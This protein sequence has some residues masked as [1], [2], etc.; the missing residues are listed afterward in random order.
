MHSQ[1]TNPEIIKQ[2]TELVAKQ[3]GSS[4]I[5]LNDTGWDSRVYSVDDGRFFFK[6]PRSEKIQGRYAQEIAALELA[7]HI[8]GVTVPDVRWYDP[9]NR[10]FGYQGVPGTLLDN[11][12]SSLSTHQKTQ[13]GRQ[14][15]TF[16]AEFHQ[17][18]F[19]GVRTKTIADEIAQFQEWYQPAIPVLRAAYTATEYGHLDQLVR[20][21]WPR[22]IEKLGRVRALCHG[23]LHLNNMLLTPD[24]AF[25][26]ID[27]G[28]VAEY[29][30]SKDF[31]D[32]DDPD[33]EEA[34]IQTYGDTPRLREKI[35]VRKKIISIIS[36]TYNI[37]KER[38][39]SVQKWLE[40][41][42]QDL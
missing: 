42:R 40:L 10:F 20:E 22:R 3:T 38:T 34:A 24:N 12:V 41:I 5:T 2:E 7:K 35:A 9:Q 16:L 28:D 11:V 25:G 1:H 21:T 36:L 4:A 15:G 27:F 8:D 6:F 26:V 13:I 18:T 33:I 37:K 32:L 39:E 29:D 17:Q 30:Q 19:P 14:I 23:D 31:V